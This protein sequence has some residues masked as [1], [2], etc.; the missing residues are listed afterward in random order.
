MS[1]YTP[2]PKSQPGG[3]SQD[4]TALN[5]VKLELRLPRK[6]S[7]KN[8]PKI[9]DRHDVFAPFAKAN[10]PPISKIIPQGNFL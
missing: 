4:V 8:S 2:K 3:E 1:Q 10:P 6:N 5:L 9:V 7:L